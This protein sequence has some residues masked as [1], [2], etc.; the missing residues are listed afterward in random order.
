MIQKC[1]ALVRFGCSR[2]FSI[3][4][5]QA[6]A[7]PV[8]HYLR[9]GDT[10]HRLLADLHEEGRLPARRV[11]VDASRLRFQKELVESFR[12]AGAEIVLDAKAAELAEP[13]KYGGFASGAPWSASGNG[14]PL[15]PEHFERRA[16]SDVIGRIARFAVEHRVNAVLAP[17][18]F[19]REGDKNPWFAVDREACSALRSA[20]D[21]EG[22]GH[23]ALDYA[24]ILPHTAL[25]DPGV[26]G[27][28]IA[29]LEDLPFDNLWVRASG[30]GSDGA[31]ATARRFITALCGL[32]NCGKPIVADY[33]GGLVG[34]ASIAYAAVCGLAHGIG[35]RERFDARSWHKPRP[36]NLEKVRGF[37]V[38]TAIRGL[39]KWLS[40]RD[41]EL[42]AKSRG[43]TRLVVCGD[44]AC[45]PHGLEDML[46]NPRRHA[47]CQRLAQ[48]RDIERIP[49][50]K[51]ERHFL[52]GEMTDVDRSARQI[53]ELKTGEEAM[54]KRLVAHSRR[55]ERLRATL[56]HLHETRGED[57]PRSPAAIR[58]GAA[59]AFHRRGE[60]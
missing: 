6:P 18:H 42:L 17:G 2:R 24:L 58:S 22:G 56:E 26:R 25:N 32:H 21:R 3:V 29:G 15:G 44:R 39:D 55:L 47:A 34:L 7:Q 9:I 27:E 36:T 35:E 19:L 1:V 50:L 57:H 41:L 54:T 40:V 5:S 43:G 31:P 38:R 53:K 45:C 20:L 49:D 23:I 13:A 4:H 60:G 11:V 16:A 52:D 8:A 51:R 59:G 37:T 48:I 10:G 28:I 14:Q 30:F 46:K 33:L 12:A